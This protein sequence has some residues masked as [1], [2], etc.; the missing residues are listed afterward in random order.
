MKIA[1]DLGGSYEESPPSLID[2]AIRDRRWCQGNLQHSR[3]VGARGLHWMNRFHLVVGILSYL[4]SVWWLFLILSGLALALQAQ[5]IRPEYFKEAYQLFPT[6]PAIDPDLELRLLGLTG[7]VLFGPKLLGL[8]VMVRDRPARR[9]AGGRRKIVA[10]FLCE[11]AASVLIAPI[12]MVMQSS[13]I[14]GILMG[15]DS[16][17]KPQRRDGGGLVL[18]EI[19]HVHRWHMASGV[20]LAVAAYA[21]SPTMLAWLSPAIAGL[22]FAAPISALTGSTRAGDWMER[23]G[24]LR[25]PEDHEKPA[26]GRIA[27]SCRT[28]HRAAVEATPDLGRLVRDDKRRRAHLALVEGSNERPRGQVDP[29]EAVTAFKIAEARTLDEAIAY[30]APEEQAFALATP[31]L[32]ERLGALS[33]DRPAA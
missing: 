27:H 29:V 20:A 17:W 15:R 8:L 21:V 16:G 31:S 33:E 9:A 32:F 24:L 3:I 23:H 6:W 11:V 18:G 2:L 5:F 10:S 22:L 25:T 12:M 26:I 4:A 28:V 30:L 7:L 19:F 14:I 1:Y 13:V